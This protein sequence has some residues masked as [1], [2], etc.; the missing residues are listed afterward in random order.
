MIDP[1]EILWPF[2]DV[3]WLRAKKLAMECA[4][5]IDRTHTRRLSPTNRS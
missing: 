5:V 1:K 3:S 4:E 2:P